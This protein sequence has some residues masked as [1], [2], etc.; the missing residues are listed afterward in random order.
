MS[1]SSEEE[2]SSE[3]S[4]SSSEGS[5]LSRELRR[6]RKV[7]NKGKRIK[8]E[9][10]P[11]KYPE[12]EITYSNWQIGLVASLFLLIGYAIYEYEYVELCA[13]KFYANVLGDKDAQHIL[14]QRYYLGSGV[15]RNKTLAFYWFKEA[16]KQGHPHA[17]YNLGV[18]HMQGFHRLERKGE[19]HK[20]IKHAAKVGIKEAEHVLKTAC[21]KGECDR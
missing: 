8:Y 3:S 6:R 1:S 7:F 17:S 13:L 2:S 18:L 5:D 4:T 21:A 20:L 9:E 16:A 14:G 19:A 12:D 11:K 10:G 15:V